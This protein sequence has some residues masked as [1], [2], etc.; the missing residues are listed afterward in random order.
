[1]GKAIT[2]VSQFDVNLV[3]AVEDRI[4]KV[5][6]YMYTDMYFLKLHCTVINKSFFILYFLS[7]FQ[8]ILQVDLIIKITV[9]KVYE[10]LF[11]YLHVYCH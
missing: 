2:L 10:K 6:I 5:M 1:M 4:S 3:H 9:K 8:Q 7:Y 11:L